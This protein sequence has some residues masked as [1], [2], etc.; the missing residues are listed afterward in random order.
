MEDLAAKLAEILSSKEGQEQLRNIQNML[1]MN[2]NP[3]TPAAPSPLPAQQGN[4]GGQNGF[5]LSALASML[6]G[7]NS[8]GQTE[9]SPQQNNGGQNTPDLSGLISALSGMNPTGASG[10]GTEENPLSGLDL[11]RIV[12]LQQAFQSM[13]GN[14]KNAQLLLALKPH[15]SERRRARVDQ[16]IRLMRLFSMLPMLQESGLFAGL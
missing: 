2:Q 12:K 5:D 6:S 13:N 8:G 16:A 15:F 4:S 14:D 7:M 10:G 9:S 11:N 1:G 3:P